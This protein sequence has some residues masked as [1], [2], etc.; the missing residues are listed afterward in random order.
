M[1]YLNPLATRQFIDWTHEQYKEHLGNE[2]GNTLMGFM[3]D[4]PDFAYIPWTP[5]IPDEFK[6]R[7]GYDVR[8]YLASFFVPQPDEEAKRIKADYWDVWSG[9]FRDNFFRV[10][11]DWCRENNIEYIVHLN[12]YRGL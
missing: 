1:D 2:F 8:P 9:L 12:H 5:E 10:Q 3:G 11:A 6:T 4:E 7:K